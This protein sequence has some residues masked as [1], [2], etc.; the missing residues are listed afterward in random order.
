M[1]NKD[2][3]KTTE[4]NDMHHN[5]EYNTGFGSYEALE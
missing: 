3:S 2:I 1:V 4:T 5:P